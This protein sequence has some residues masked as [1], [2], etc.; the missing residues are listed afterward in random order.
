MDVASEVSS[1]VFASSTL[2]IS[3]RLATIG[4]PVGYQN[5]KCSAPSL[6]SSTSSSLLSAINEPATNTELNNKLAKPV[7]GY[8][9]RA[10]RNIDRWRDYGDALKT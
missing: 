2:L 5:E 7:K 9:K 1:A 6:T 3:V 10:R 8:P 4:Q